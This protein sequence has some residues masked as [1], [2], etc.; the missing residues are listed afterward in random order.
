MNSFDLALKVFLFLAPIVYWQN[1]PLAQIQIQFFQFGTI[2]LFLVALSQNK[3]RNLE[4]KSLFALGFICFL[5]IFIAKTPF[6]NIAMTNILFALLLYYL[7][8]CYAK[9]IKCIFKI[10]VALSILNTLLAIFQKFGIDFVYDNSSECCAFLA[11]SAFHGDFQALVLPLAFYLHPLLAIFPIVGL[12]LSKSA[13]G[14]AAVAV[15]LTFLLIWNKKIKFGPIYFLALFSAFSAF[16]IHFREL[17]FYKMTMR[18]EIWQETLKLIFDRSYRG[19]GFGSIKGF[20]EVLHWPKYG[21]ADRIYND[22]LEFALCVG[23]I[24]FIFFAVFVCNKIKRYRKAQQTFLL[25]TVFASCIIAS[26]ICLFHSPMAPLFSGIG[27]SPRIAIVM[28]TILAMLE[29]LLQRGEITDG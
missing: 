16:I 24:G 13:T 26:V 12:V 10:L 17:L 6:S 20:T 14:L 18:F 2:F 27:E 23:I 21:T 1:L 5:N 3:Q 4:D 29:I 25:D 15:G 11:T 19:W 9:N 28:I 22:Y 8:V 7:I